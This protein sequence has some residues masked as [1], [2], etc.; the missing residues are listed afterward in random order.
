MP[1]LHPCKVPTLATPLMT[2]VLKLLVSEHTPRLNVQVTTP[3]I[4]SKF[5]VPPLGLV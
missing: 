4:G 3:K 1:T 5:G 2:Q